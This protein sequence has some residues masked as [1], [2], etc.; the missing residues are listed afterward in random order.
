MIQGGVVMVC[1]FFKNLSDNRYVDKNI[2][3]L[4]NTVVQ[5]KQDT[6]LTEPVLK[7]VGVDFVN[8]AECNYCFIPDLKRYYY[9]TNITYTQGRVAEISC[10]VDVLMSFKSSYRQLSA[11]VERQESRYN[12]Y[13]TDDSFLTNNKTQLFVHEW[14]T[15][16]PSPHMY[17]LT[18]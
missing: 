18:M 15:G 11:T 1:T 4:Y 5:F 13:L 9:I 17:L 16:L 2:V 3:E 10:H 7:I 14:G 6:S 12:T 8:L